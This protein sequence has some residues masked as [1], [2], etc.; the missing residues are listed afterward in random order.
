LRPIVRRD[1]PRGGRSNRGSGCLR[2]A[3][4]GKIGRSNLSGGRKRMRSLKYGLS[5]AAAA[6]VLV[7]LQELSVR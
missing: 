7:A 2:A 6:I 1:I 3:A 4:S 5:L